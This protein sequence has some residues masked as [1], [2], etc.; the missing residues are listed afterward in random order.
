[1]NEYDVE[2]I[3]L[4][5][6]ESSRFNGDKR[7]VPFRNTPL[8]LHGVKSLL[9]S[10]VRTVNLIKRPNDREI[11]STINDAGLNTDRI[12]FLTNPEPD[13]GQIT[14]VQLGLQELSKEASAAMIV[15]ADMPFLPSEVINKLRNQ[16]QAHPEKFLVPVHDGHRDQPRII[17]RTFFE[18]F[19][20]LSRDQRGKDVVNQNEERVRTLPFEESKWFVDIDTRSDYQTHS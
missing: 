6:G 10:N 15:P 14:S 13:R 20:A 9:E 1:M 18:A 17:P 12:R 3:Y 2:A 19:L 5:A 16:H 8:F 11:R 7:W 4:M